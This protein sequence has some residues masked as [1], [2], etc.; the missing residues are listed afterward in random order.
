MGQSIPDVARR[1]MNGAQPARWLG[2]PNNPSCH[3]DI[4]V[5]ASTAVNICAPPGPLPLGPQI[6]PPSPALVLILLTLQA[7][8]SEPRPVACRPDT[9]LLD[10]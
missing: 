2:A 10:L 8:S 5:T 9:P 7:L 6:S 1:S 4:E 3:W